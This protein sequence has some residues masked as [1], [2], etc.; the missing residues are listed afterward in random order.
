M[1]KNTTDIVMEAPVAR[2]A[3]C[4]EYRRTDG[5]QRWLGA[6]LLAG[7]LMAIV[8]GPAAA[9]FTVT[10]TADS[11]AG[12]LRQAILDANQAGSA[13][14]ITFNNGLGTVTL[15]SALP[16]LTNPNGISIDGGTG[17]SVSGNSANR[18]FFI[19]ITAD[20]TA[21]AGSTLTQTPA[22]AAFSISNLTLSNGK[23][24]GGSAA[25]ATDAGGGG[26][27]L[28]GAIFLNAGTLS[29]TNVAFTGNAAVGGSGGSSTGVV[30]GRSGGGGMGGASNQAVAGG[31]GS[32]GGGFGVGATGAPNNGLAGQFTGGTGL[33]GAAGGNGTGTTGGASGGGGGGG[34][35]TNN[36]AAGGGG[37]GGQASAGTAGGAGGFGGG[38]GGSGTGTTITG[39]AGGYG[40]GG[41]GGN[42]NGGNA[43]FGGGGGGGADDIGVSGFAG[44]SAGG[45]GTT[46]AGGGGAGLGGAVFVRQGATL[47]LTG[48]SFT[49]SS[50]QGGGAGNPSL[51]AGG[52]FGNDV[53]LAGSASYTVPTDTTVTLGNNSLGGGSN[54]QI[55]GGFTKAGGGTLVLSGDN[56]YTGGTNITA[57]TL[58]VVDSF[59][60]TGRGPVTVNSTATLGGTGGILGQVTV[61][62]GGFIS[63]G[64]PTTAGQLTVDQGGGGMTLAGTYNWKLANLADSATGTPGTDFDQLLLTDNDGTGNVAEFAGGSVALD[65]S[66]LPGQDPNSANAFWSASHS[67]TIADANSNFVATDGTPTLIDSTYADGTFALSN[68]GDIDLTFTPSTSMPMPEP[69]SAGL[70]ALCAAGALARRPRRP[71]QAE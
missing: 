41:G 21:A 46:T 68:N 24:A 17:N 65:F 37:V 2:G 13:A 39:G 16:V 54:S 67:W 57:G 8:A 29:L 1:M 28:G 10:T 22:A 42:L 32:G 63:P 25:K 44:G 38:G 7:L 31:S 12:S 23:A 33:V 60:S 18:I 6:T 50:V 69:G 9:Q 53:F 30:T 40:G 58:R 55:T 11:G 45:G 3:G 4:C 51:S 49:G 14:T 20:T 27:G 71:T 34:S 61:N 26:A 62:S 36:A 48:G 56:S 47:N 35:V 19:G 66:L 15:A 52:A 64:T 70:V 59:S 5:S 43:G